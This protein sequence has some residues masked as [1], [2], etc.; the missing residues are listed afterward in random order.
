MARG[1]HFGSGLRRGFVAVKRL[2][3]INSH[4]PYAKP[5]RIDPILR[6][7]AKLKIWIIVVRRMA[8][9]LAPT[10]AKLS[11]LVAAL[12]KYRIPQSSEEAAQHAIEQALTREG[13]RIEPQKVLS[14]GERID[15]FTDGIAIEIKV[16]GGRTA[17]YRQLE[18]YARIETVTGLLL[19]TGIAWPLVSD[20]IF[21]KPLRAHLLGAAWL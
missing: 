4:T 11:A 21:E 16:K 10:E 6:I 18:R 17:I 7:I 9:G 5:C 2:G 20:V 14:A 3:Y 1:E 12:R 19:V 13:F 15:I 8:E